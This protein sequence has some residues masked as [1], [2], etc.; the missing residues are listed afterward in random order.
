[1]LFVATNLVI[2]TTRRMADYFTST[3][4]KTWSAAEWAIV[5]L[6]IFAVI[7][8]CILIAAFAIMSKKQEQDRLQILGY[9]KN[10]NNIV[11]MLQKPGRKESVPTQSFDN[12]VRNSAPMYDRS[13]G[14]VPR[15][16]P[17]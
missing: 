10:G 3:N 1:M 11:P 7:I 5:G 17:Y 9:N 6:I 8:I 4:I 12:I 13:Q 2:L 16:N 14:Y 15:F